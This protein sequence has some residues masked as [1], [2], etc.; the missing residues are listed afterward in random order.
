MYYIAIEN[1]LYTLTPKQYAEWEIKF[2]NS[3]DEIHEEKLD[4]V[5]KNG[6]LI[7]NVLQFNY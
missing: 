6:K 2:P 1:G 7:G 5:K 4:W 3:S